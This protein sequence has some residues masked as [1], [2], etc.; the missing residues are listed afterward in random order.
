MD[1]TPYQ[2][3]AIVHLNKAGYQASPYGD[4]KVAVKDPVRTMNG[5]I[6]GSEVR[7]IHVSQVGRFISERN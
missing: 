1:A 6:I 3:T 5:A 7:V 4:E 2:Q